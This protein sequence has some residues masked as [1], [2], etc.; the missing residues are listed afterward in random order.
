MKK[1]YVLLAYPRS[2]SNWLAYIIDALWQIETKGLI[3]DYTT[4]RFFKVARDDKVIV[5]CHAHRSFERS[6]IEKR[7][8][9]ILIIRDP[10][11][12][13]FSHFKKCNTIITLESITDQLLNTITKEGR[14]DWVYPIKI[15][16]EF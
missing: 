5:R 11:E 9:L 1:E 10:L 3:E 6:Q 14:T 4:P 12:S 13:I 8:N 15:Y 16:D 2:G 7:E